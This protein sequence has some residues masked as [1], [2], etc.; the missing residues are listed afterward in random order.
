MSVHKFS[1][2]CIRINLTL[3]HALWLA[4]LKDSL[5]S[6]LMETIIDCEQ[7]RED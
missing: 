3:R 6:C 1:D 4:Y 2:N 5:E 7:S